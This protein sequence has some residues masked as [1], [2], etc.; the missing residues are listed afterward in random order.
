[1]PR[2]LLRV[3]YFILVALRRL[4]ASRIG[5]NTFEFLRLAVRVPKLVE[6]IFQ[7]RS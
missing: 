1:M 4:S 5:L 3:V 6:K 2:A 7:A